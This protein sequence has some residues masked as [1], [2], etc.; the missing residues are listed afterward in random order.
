MGGVDVAVLL[1]VVVEVAGAKNDLMEV[2]FCFFVVPLDFDGGDAILLEP[3]SSMARSLRLSPY[4][5]NNKSIAPL[6]EKEQLLSS[7]T[8]F[9]R[10]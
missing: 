1:V 6:D 3:G 5:L 2:C 9:S 10:L 7:L 4:W 8:K